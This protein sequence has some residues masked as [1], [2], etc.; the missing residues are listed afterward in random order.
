MKWYLIVV[1]ICISLIMSDIEHLFLCLLAICMMRHF[2]YL[3]KERWSGWAHSSSVG[4]VKAEHF[5]W[6]VTEEEV[7]D[8]AGE[9][10]GA[11]C[12]GCQVVGGPGMGMVSAASQWAGK[13]QSCSLS[14]LNGCSNENPVPWHLDSALCDFLYFPRVIWKLLGQWLI[15]S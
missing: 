1:L 8:T 2:C 6:Q 5:L 14:D 4:A 10:M 11:S 9:G 13:P 7:R 3:V 15:S 12:A